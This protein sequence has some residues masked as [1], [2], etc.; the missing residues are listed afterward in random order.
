[1]SEIDPSNRVRFHLT[2]YY[3]I[4]VTDEIAVRTTA[5]FPKGVPD[6]DGLFAQVAAAQPIEVLVRDQLL[7]D[8]GNQ[9][10]DRGFEI[11]LCGPV[12]THKKDLPRYAE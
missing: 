8:H 11:K 1:M 2:I 12:K 7:N 6:P 5:S 4:E 9:G 3:L 10:G